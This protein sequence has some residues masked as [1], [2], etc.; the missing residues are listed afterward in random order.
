LGRKFGPESLNVYDD[1]SVMSLP[2]FIP[3]DDEGVMPGKTTLIEKGVLAG[4]LHSRETAEKMGEGLT[5]NGR[6][7]NVMRQPI[8]R[9]T[10]T[11]IE[12]GERKPEE[13]FESIGDGIYAVDVI[14]GQTNLEMFTFTSGY[15][16]ALRN[17]KKGRMYKD[18]V[19][20]GNVFHTLNNIGMIAD[21][22]RMFG[23]LGGCGKGGQGPLPVSFG[24]PHILINDVLIGGR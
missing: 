3:F 22:L 17:G 12:R 10:N 4:R 15:G 9:M 18:I 19:L 2:G 5:G 23:G 14:G 24:G 13:L 16:F 6:A 1:G 21:D 8:V 7:L 20:S 11:Y